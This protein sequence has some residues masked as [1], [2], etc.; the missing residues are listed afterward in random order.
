MGRGEE[1]V[2]MRRPL[3]AL[4]VGFALLPADPARAL[5]HIAHISEL[6][7]VGGGDPTDQYVEIEME[8][9]FQTLVT[10]SVL[11]AWDCDGDHLG[12]LLVVPNDVSNDGA[13]VRWIMAT[14]DPVG[15]IT[16]DFVIPTAGIVPTCG[17][18]CWGAPGA[19]VPDPN[20]WNHADPTQYVDC[21]AYGGYSGPT[22]PGSAPPTTDTPAT[23]Y[24][25]VQ[26]ND[27]LSVACP[28]PENNAGA[29]GS[30]GKCVD[31]TTTT[32]ATVVT[33]STSVTTTTAPAS[34]DLLPGRKLLLKVKEGKPERSSILLFSDKTSAVTLG[35]G[36]NSPDDPTQAGGLLLV[37]SSPGGGF[38]DVYP[39]DPSGWK[40]RR[41]NEVV[42]GW[43]YKD[44]DG[45]VTSVS[46]KG[47][48]SVAVQAKG[49]ALGHDLD[50]DPNPV[51]V[52]VAI[53][54]HRYCLAFGGTQR[55]TPN[56][57]FLAQKAPAPAAC[58]GLPD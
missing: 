4:I 29:I 28:S 31:P 14:K 57:K 20:S 44:P 24:A 42:R 2:S 38:I 50:D 51:A 15:G 19:S 32:T 36:E 33:T 27:T 49:S 55:F 35:R 6:N 48:K 3:F 10:D 53:G 5:F 18:V 26:E 52:V 25:I 7:A 22:R 11:G 34:A 30:Y 41:K 23:G 40:A 21:I 56:K 39:L 13:S 37:A 58:A 9:D 8:F 46:I 17:Q 54:E 45:P 43:G 1:E 47:G 12:D 16:P